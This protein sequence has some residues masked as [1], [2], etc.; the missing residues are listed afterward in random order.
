MRR[1]LPVLLLLVVVAIVAYLFGAGVVSVSVDR[2]RL[3]EKADPAVEAT[4]DAAS[5]L[6]EKARA[7]G[8]V[9]ANETDEAAGEIREE[10]SDKPA[11]SDAR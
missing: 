10:L 5:R 4:T 6:T 9:V 3:R 2:E 1:A 11:D 8:R 7:A